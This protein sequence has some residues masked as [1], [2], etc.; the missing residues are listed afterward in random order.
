MA[1]GE[2][3]CVTRFPMKMLMAVVV[4]A[5]LAGGLCAQ[6]LRAQEAHSVLRCIVI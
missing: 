2:V 4:L 5:V 3:V 1:M 6:D